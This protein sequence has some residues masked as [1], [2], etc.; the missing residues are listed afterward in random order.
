MADKTSVWVEVRPHAERLLQLVSDSPPTGE[1]EI[2]TAHAYIAGM[3]WRARRLYE[4]VLLLLKA[5]LPEEAAFLARSLFEEGLRLQQLA[6]EPENRDALI[7]Y[8][9]NASISQQQ[10]LMETAKASG[11]DPDISEVSA[12]LE[13]RRR[14]LQEYAVRHGVKR[15][16]QFQTVRDAAFRFGRKEDFWTY[17]WAHESVHGSDAMWLFA[18]RKRGVDTV[19]LHAKT[20]DPEVLSGFAH[21]AAKSMAEA[22]DAAFTIFGWTAAPEFQQVVSD[23]ERVLDSDKR[24]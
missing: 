10:G 16:R 22:A 12:A 9:A 17:Q 13:E 5:E 11:L 21:V 1:F 14:N 24:P 2:P 20:N 6:T 23:I 8:W 7:L 15:R 3:F 4:G 19:A 18:R